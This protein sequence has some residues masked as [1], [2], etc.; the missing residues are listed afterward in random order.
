MKN[1]TKLGRERSGNGSGFLVLARRVGREKN[2]E[3]K[4]ELGKNKKGRSRKGRREVG[5]KKAKQT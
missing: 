4:I 5:K 3:E 1:F 2:R